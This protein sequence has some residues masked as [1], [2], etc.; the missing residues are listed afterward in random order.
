MISPVK[1]CSWALSPQ[2]HCTPTTLVPTLSTYLA[3]CP[4][5]IL[6]QLVIK[7]NKGWVKS[8]LDVV[9]GAVFF[10]C[11]LVYV[12]FCGYVDESCLDK[13]GISIYL[14]NCV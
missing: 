9:F 8:G 2:D 6:N 3:L 12:E 11:L 7:V 10:G 1:Q 5:A 4:L 13:P 14:G